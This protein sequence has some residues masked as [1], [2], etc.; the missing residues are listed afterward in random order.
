VKDS[1][2]TRREFLETSLKTGGMFGAGASALGGQQSTGGNA[3]RAT[4]NPPVAPIKV[5]VTSACVTCPSHLRNCSES[6]A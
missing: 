3:M 4:D 5:A 6:R 2:W 1:D